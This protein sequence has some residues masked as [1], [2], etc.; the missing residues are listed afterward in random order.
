MIKNV[1]KKNGKF[2]ILFLILLVLIGYPMI[3]S[4]I[5]CNDELI[6]RYVRSLGFFALIKDNILTA[7]AKGRTIGGYFDVRWLSFL[8]ENT[9]VNRVVD[10]ALLLVVF[11]LFAYF[12]FRI[13]NNK[14]FSMFLFVMLF[15]CLPITFEHGIPNAFIA[16]TVGPLI[17]LLTSFLLYMS[18]FETKI[19]T[20]LIISMVLYFVAM[21][22]Y[23]FVVTYIFIYWILALYYLS[24]NTKI[25]INTIKSNW[26]IFF[27]PFILTFG[28]IIFYFVIQH[29]FP[30]NYEGN[31]IE[32]L[33]FKQVI[34]ILYVL[35]KSAMPGY[36]LTNEKYRWLLNYHEQDFSNMT[37]LYVVVAV[38]MLAL[39][40]AIYSIV[41]KGEVRKI[42]K[43][44]L[45]I[46][47]SVMYMI[48]PSMPNSI[49]SLYQ[50]TLSESFFTWLPVST[51][52]YCAAVLVVSLIVWKIL[53]KFNNKIVFITIALVCVLIGQIQYMN[54]V[55]AHQHQYNYN[56]IISIEH[57]IQTNFFSEF[58]GRT[59]NSADIFESRNLLAVHDSYWT[60]YGLTRGKYV[61]IVKESTSPV[62]LFYYNDELFVVSNGKNVVVCS[63]EELNGKYIV[64]VNDNQEVI[65]DFSGGILDQGFYMYGFSFV[66][67]TLYS[68]EFN[69]VEYELVNSADYFL[70]K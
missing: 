42:Q 56:R 66:E 51:F 50:A 52:L 23:E 53:S 54:Y 26:L 2:N 47:V 58:H 5:M 36:F 1:T 27:V 29:Y 25:S 37:M 13:V 32:I 16:I 8:S 34:Y 38:I 48:L 61:N 64:K 41:G 15:C 40:A 12:I 44:Y 18:Y 33:S 68:E 63:E 65:G 7:Q 59:V 4:G 6:T 9:I 14:K 55:F 57:L 70:E 17:I 22:Q 49:S 62:Q 3:I 39:G 31:T 10:V 11:L 19:E 46:F 60:S 35:A 20:R 21:V 69:E 67:G 28:Y 24:K 45:V 43:D 30:S